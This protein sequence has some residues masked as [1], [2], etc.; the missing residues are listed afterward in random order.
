MCRGF[1]AHW[2]H[3]AKHFTWLTNVESL[4]EEVEQNLYKQI[5]KFLKGGFL[6]NISW[7]IVSIMG[8]K[9]SP[10]KLADILKSEKTPS[11]V[12]NSVAFP[13]L[14]ELRKILKLLA[15]CMKEK[16]L[17]IIE[18]LLLEQD[19]RLLSRST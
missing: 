4:V 14:D 7:R 1:F 17:F 19:I 2:E 18:L 5:G 16:F 15:N 6:V 10:K 12:N 9:S 3:L 11:K 8:K 13:P